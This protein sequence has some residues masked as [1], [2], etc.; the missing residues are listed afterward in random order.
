MEKGMRQIFADQAN[1]FVGKSFDAGP[2]DPR[3]GSTFE[4]NQF[5]LRVIMPNV[6]QIC[7]PL[8]FDITGYIVF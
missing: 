4:V 3:S 7:S 1:I 5:D 2:D 6:E 8:D